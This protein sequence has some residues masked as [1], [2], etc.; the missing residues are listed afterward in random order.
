MITPSEMYFYL[1]WSGAEEE[2]EEVEDQPIHFRISQ[3]DKQLVL[4]A[5]LQNRQ[6]PLFLL[7][8]SQ[9]A[10]QPPD[11]SDDIFFRL[12]SSYIACTDDDHYFSRRDTLGA[13]KRRNYIAN[14]SK[15]TTEINDREKR[16]G[17]EERRGL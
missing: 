12:L 16:R 15:R 1:S 17:E 13:T 9:P 11:W 5:P 14:R 4:P 8:L 7:L 10:S 3:Q 2:Q 6:R